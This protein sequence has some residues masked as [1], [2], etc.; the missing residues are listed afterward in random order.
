MIKN[1]RTWAMGASLAALGTLSVVGVALGQGGWTPPD[2]CHCGPV[3]DCNGIPMR[4]STYCE[5]GW[6]CACNGIEH[7]T[8]D[9]FVGLEAICYQPSGN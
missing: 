4:H 1:A 8:E 5:P 7:A 6:A 2:N 9:C 3:D